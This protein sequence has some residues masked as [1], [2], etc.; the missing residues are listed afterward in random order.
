M[1]RLRR[2]ASEG[3]TLIEVM[4]A[5]AVIAIAMGAIVA[6]SSQFTRTADYL[7]QKTFASWVAENAYAQIA[8]HDPWPSIGQ[9]HG[10]QKMAGQEWRWTADVSGTPDADLRRIDIHVS[11]ADSPKGRVATLTGFLG[12]HALVPSPSSQQPQ[13]HAP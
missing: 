5:L 8:D 11:P 6:V 13:S 7:R 4:I 12:R 9:Q 10:R 3:F 1:A 2:S